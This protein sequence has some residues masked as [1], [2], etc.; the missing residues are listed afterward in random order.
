MNEII[1]K[2]HEVRYSILD[3][4]SKGSRD[5]DLMRTYRTQMKDIL[6]V[7]DQL[8]KINP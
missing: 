5:E 6:K 8:Q 1:E 2:L 3:V 4:Y 7:I